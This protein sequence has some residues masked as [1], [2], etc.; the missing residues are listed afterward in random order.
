MRTTTFLALG[1]VLVLAA[2]GWAGDEE[3]TIDWIY[4][5]EGKNATAMPQHVWTTGGDLLLLDGCASPIFD[6]L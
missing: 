1:L 6:R 3:L 4:S 2:P 5:D